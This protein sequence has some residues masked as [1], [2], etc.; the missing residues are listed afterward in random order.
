MSYPPLSI[1]F[2]EVVRSQRKSARIT[3]EELAERAAIHPTYVGLVERGKRNPSLDVAERIAI[4]L[5]TSLANLII[6]ADAARKAS[7]KGGRKRP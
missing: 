6:L 3:Q 7:E 1:A 4:A 2:G 5:G